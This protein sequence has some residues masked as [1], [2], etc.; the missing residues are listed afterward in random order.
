MAN[1]GHGWFAPILLKNSEVEQLHKV[2]DISSLLQI[3]LIAAVNAV[4]ENPAWRVHP[5]YEK[6]TTN[7]AP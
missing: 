1:Y 6:T 3:G 5:R 7:P 4:R 2:A